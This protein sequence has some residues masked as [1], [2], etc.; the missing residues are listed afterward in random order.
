LKDWTIVLLFVAFFSVSKI[1]LQVVEVKSFSYILSK[2]L[3]IN[4]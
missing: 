2:V 3:T 1:T 4:Y